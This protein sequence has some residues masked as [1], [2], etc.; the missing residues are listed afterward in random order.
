MLASPAQHHGSRQRT[1]CVV[2]CVEWHKY[3]SL[4]ASISLNP[5]TNGC[6]R[7]RCTSTGVFISHMQILSYIH[8]I[9][10]HLIKQRSCGATGPVPTAASAVCAACAWCTACAIAWGLRLAML[11]WQQRGPPAFPWPCT[12]QPFTTWGDSRGV[13]WPTPRGSPHV[14]R[15]AFAACCTL[16]DTT[17]GACPVTGAANQSPHST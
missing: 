16:A 1:S 7:R 9:K 5:A 8:L 15:A 12:D 11:A 6:S 10:P 2:E 4:Y 17:I 3:A 13:G 14:G